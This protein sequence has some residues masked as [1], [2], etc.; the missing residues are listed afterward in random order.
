MLQNI[1]INLTVTNSLTRMNG[2]KDFWR[3]V[4]FELFKLDTKV[5]KCIF[6]KIKLIRIINIFLIRFNA[7]FK[8]KCGWQR[9]KTARTHLKVSISFFY[10][11]LISRS[12]FNSKLCSAINQKPSIFDRDSFFSL[13]NSGQ[14][15]NPIPIS[16][17]RNSC[18]FDTEKKLS[19]RIP[20]IT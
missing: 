1:L 9:S 13:M 20:Y 5:S 16:A 12:R 17:V 15:N 6:Y 2:C 8:S 3:C 4:Y 14:R 18:A 11:T 10:F 7:I 19:I